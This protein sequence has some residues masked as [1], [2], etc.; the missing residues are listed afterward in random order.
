M[1]TES[2]RTI[3][4]HH[5]LADIKI[6]TAAHVCD[7]TLKCLIK[8]ALDSYLE[9]ENVTARIVHDDTQKRHGNDYQTPGYYLQLYRHR[10]GL[11]QVQLAEKSGVKQHHLSEMEHN[12]RPIGKVLARR[13]SDILNF[14]YRILL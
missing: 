2:Y 1:H 10:S 3:E 9:S 6:K 4:S 14:D 5:A 11:T 13:L 12:K 7:T 8:L